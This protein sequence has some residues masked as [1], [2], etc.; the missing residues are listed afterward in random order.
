MRP[1]NRY[2]LLL[3]FLFVLTTIIL[4]TTERG[5][6]FYFSIYLIECLLLTLLFSQIKPRARRGLVNVGYV[7]FG[8]FLVLVG[9]KVLEILT[10]ITIS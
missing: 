7:L 8:S 5:L 6:D 2:I 1:Y 3:A 10:D 4:S 9:V